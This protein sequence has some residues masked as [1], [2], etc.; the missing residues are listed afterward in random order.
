M[1]V[2]DIKDMVFLVSL[3]EEDKKNILLF[4]YTKKLQLEYGMPTHWE[5][6]MKC[7]RLR[8]TRKKSEKEV[9]KYKN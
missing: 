9:T 5:Y 8:H 4:A 2:L 6:Q 3:L 1:A 7:K